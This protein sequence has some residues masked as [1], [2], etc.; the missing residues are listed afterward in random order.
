MG[1][2]NR[3][4]SESEKRQIPEL[5]KLSFDFYYRLAIGGEPL[6]YSYREPDTPKGRDMQV[7]VNAMAN[8]KLEGVIVDIAFDS[9]WSA[10]WVRTSKCAD[11][12]LMPDNVW[13]ESSYDGSEF[14]EKR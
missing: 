8:K 11:F 4:L 12:Y 3:E 10:R 14:E 13:Q 5:Q 1:K 2:L 7:E 6:T 9:D